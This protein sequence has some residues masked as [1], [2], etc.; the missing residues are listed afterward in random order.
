MDVY[1]KKYLKY[2]EKYIGLK[3]QL[4]KIQLGGQGNKTI[5][6]SKK[7]ANKFNKEI[8]DSL[9]KEKKDNFPF[10][11]S[12]ENPYMCSLSSPSFGLCKKNIKK[13]NKYEG[14]T[15]YPIYDISIDSDPEQERKKMLE[16]GKNFNY[17][18]QEGK[19]CS[20]LHEN[21]HK[22]YRSVK[23]K[24]PEKFKILTWN[25]WWSMK[26]TNNEREDNFH[27]NF[28]KTRMNEIIRQIEKSEADI[29]CLQEVGELTF[30]LIYPSLSSLYPY[31][32]EEPISFDTNGIDEKRGRKI[33]TICIS[34]YPCKSFKLFGVEGNLTYHNSMLM[35]EFDNFVVFN[36][37]LQAGT[38]YSPGQ[39]DLWYNY[40]RCRYNEY[41]AI[42]NQIKKEKFKKPII[43]LGDFNTNLNGSVDEWVELKAFEQMNLE[44]LWLTKYDNTGG[45]TENTQINLMR[46][47][48]KFEEKIYR[49]DGIFSTKNA[50][51]VQDIKLIGTDPIQIDNELQQQFIQ[52]RVPNKPERET[53][54]RMNDNQ[55][56]LWASDHFGVL[57]ELELKD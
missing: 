34:K 25:L 4:E 8:Y 55:I 33:E 22:I 47:N 53:L 29:V 19:N 41:L 27:L 2:K 49:I 32:Y 40:S 11:C 31:F 7:K 21:S 30:N 50:F 13:C 45:F 15:E 46:W 48:V 38:K 10:Y 9:T 16:Y 23:E 52:Y 35:L 24:V 3:E 51:D 14:E 37:Y 5:L 42:N 44:D 6:Q 36:V 39:K 12:D 26:K 28:F 20:I 57:A 43:V 54:I 17:N 1:K 56:E 18:L